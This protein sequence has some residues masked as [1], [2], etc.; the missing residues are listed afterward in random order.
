VSATQDL[1]LDLVVVRG[2]Y[3][4]VAEEEEAVF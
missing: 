4:Q 3:A 2:H 1:E